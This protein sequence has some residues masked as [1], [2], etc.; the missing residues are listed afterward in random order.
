M[1]YWLPLSFFGGFYLLLLASCLEPVAPEFQLE[2]PFF[3]VEGGIIVGENR[4]NEVRI[5]R[6]NFRE[7]A[8]YFQPVTDARLTSVEAGGEVVDWYLVDAETGRYQA[9]ED[10][11]PEVGQS[12]QFEIGFPDG[13]EAVSAPELIPEPVSITNLRIQFEQNSI[14]DEGR[15]RFIPRFELYADY[16]DPAGTENYYQ[17]E[18]VAWEKLQVCASCEGAIWRD[19]IC[20]P[21]DAFIIRYDYPCDPSLCFESKRGKEVVFTSDEVSDG[22]SVRDLP[23]GGINFD[24]IGGL[25]VVAQLSSITTS[26][27]EYGKVISDLVNG[28]GALNSTIPV[29][30]DGNIRNL[31]PSGPTVLGFL[32]AR[33]ATET[34]AF[35][36][37]TYDTGTP[38]P[39]DGLIR[40]E[41]PLGRIRAPCDGPN[42][43]TTVP[44]GWP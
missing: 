35:T 9:P 2:E 32:S 4:V 41:D 24:R 12:W 18:Y 29:A 40:L 25:L 19:G 11:A 27:F 33:S 13:T 6:S 22:S 16:E 23:L 43:I 42:R 8:L 17:V 31:D 10:F 26:A 21:Q 3:L 15:N 30:L 20:I 7:L 37:I 34:R 28:S 44:E 14:F 38:L 36:E 5:Q 1:P 39:F